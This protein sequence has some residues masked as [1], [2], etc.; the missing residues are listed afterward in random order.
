MDSHIILPGLRAAA[1]VVGTGL[2]ALAL[3][4]CTGS[5]APASGTSG[6][7]SQGRQDVVVTATDLK[8]DPPTFSVI[9]GRP[10]QLTFTNKGVI[11]HDW[12]P[13]GLEAKDVQIVAMPSVLSS[14]MAEHAKE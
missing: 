3:T 12:S 9:A 2:A 13:V 4:A 6:G 14:Q 1:V 5:P 11:E 10:V 7:E 8:L